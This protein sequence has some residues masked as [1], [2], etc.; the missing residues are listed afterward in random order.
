MFVI[1]PDPPPPPRPRA[2]WLSW[3]KCHSFSCDLNFRTSKARM[4]VRCPRCGLN[5]RVVVFP[6]W[7]YYGCKPLHAKA[8]WRRSQMSWSW[9]STCMYVQQKANCHNTT[10]S[11]RDWKNYSVPNPNVHVQSLLHLIA[12]VV[13]VEDNQ[14]APICQCAISESSSDP[15]PPSNWT[16]IP[17]HRPASMS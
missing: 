1:F 15:L 10:L 17:V 6:R 13:H 12:A 5:S 16:C 9:C 8:R 7:S 14:A 4:C 11:F 3:P 2:A